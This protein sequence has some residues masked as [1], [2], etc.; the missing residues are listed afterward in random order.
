MDLS[1]G[2]NVDLDADSRGA[3]AADFDRDGDLAVE[4]DLPV[5]GGVTSAQIAYAFQLWELGLGEFTGF[6][7]E[8][9]GSAT[10]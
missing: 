10:P 4:M 8:Y 9:P 1:H 7:R 2:S 3:V 5:K 6:V